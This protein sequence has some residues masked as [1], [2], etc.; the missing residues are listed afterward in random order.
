M[1]KW[2]YIL[3][4]VSTVSHAE[5]DLDKKNGS[6]SGNQLR[7]LF[8]DQDT[9]ISILRLHNARLQQLL[10]PSQAIDRPHVTIRTQLSKVMVNNSYDLLHI[11]N[12]LIKDEAMTLLDLSAELIETLRASLD[13]TQGQ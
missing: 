6:L 13:A 11:N 8:A 7:M 2:L 12:Q 10:H 1:K 4:I 3:T 5:K 9:I